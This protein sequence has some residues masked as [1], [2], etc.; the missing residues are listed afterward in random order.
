MT[1]PIW[2][3][4]RA[5]PGTS[6]DLVVADPAS[7]FWR[8]AG[9]HEG[10]A[11]PGL[12]QNEF[13]HVDLS[14]APASHVQVL[15]HSPVPG[16]LGFADTTYVALPGKGGVWSSGTST[17]ALAMSAG[18]RLPASVMHHP[19]PGV[20]VPVIDAMKNLYRVFGRGPA[21]ARHPSEPNVTD[22]Y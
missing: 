10:S 2:P 14:S 5:S 8:K 16:G 20:T 12:E 19:V 17:W 9:V 13:N 3:D 18:T 4:G 7:W 1:S 22:Y 11:L 15:S 21:G 6:W